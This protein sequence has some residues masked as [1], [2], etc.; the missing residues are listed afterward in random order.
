[1]TSKSVQN[2]APTF[3]SAIIV[4]VVVVMMVVIPVHG[5]N[6]LQMDSDLGTDV[7]PDNWNIGISLKWVPTARFNLTDIPKSTLITTGFPRDKDI[8]VC[9]VACKC[10]KSVKVLGKVGWK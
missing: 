7:Y 5:Q 8:F 3:T 6:N 10:R 1:M 2:W 4:A 9:R